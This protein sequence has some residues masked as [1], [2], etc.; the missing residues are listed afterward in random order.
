MPMPWMPFNLQKQ[1][2][3]ACNLIFADHSLVKHP[4]QKKLSL[5][6]RKEM[7]LVETIAGGPKGVQ[8]N[9]GKASNF[10]SPKGICMD[11]ARNLYVADTCNHVIRKIT[12]DRVV[13]TYAGTHGGKSAV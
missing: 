11:D 13:S 1:T 10:S 12:P 5:R 4:S 6:R 2:K 9:H 3:E 8:D 7:Y